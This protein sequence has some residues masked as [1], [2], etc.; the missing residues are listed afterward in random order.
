MPPSRNRVA[1]PPR[2]GSTAALTVMEPAS[3]VTLVG[4]PVAPVVVNSPGSVGA[5]PPVWSLSEKVVISP[6]AIWSSWLP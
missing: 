1:T 4:S 2:V 5:L 6:D 3:P